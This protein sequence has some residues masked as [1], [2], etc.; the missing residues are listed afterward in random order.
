MYSN[1]DILCIVSEKNK[2]L[3]FIDFNILKKIYTKGTFKRI[4]HNE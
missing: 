1:Y 2:T 3:Y 4:Y